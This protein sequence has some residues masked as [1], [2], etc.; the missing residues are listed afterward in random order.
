MKTQLH[1]LVLPVRLWKPGRPVR[2]QG[3]DTHQL[4]EPTGQLPLSAPSGD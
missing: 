1:P 4:S 3:A 2:L